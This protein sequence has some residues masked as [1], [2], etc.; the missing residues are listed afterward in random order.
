LADYEQL[1]LKTPGTQID[2]VAVRANFDP[3]LRAKSFSGTHTLVILPVLGTP[4]SAGLRQAVKNYLYP[5]RVIGT[6]V[7][8]IG[9]TF[10]EVAVRA[11]V[12]AHS[13]I[14]KTDLKQKI[15]EALNAFFDP[16]TGGPDHTG[17]PLGRDVYRSEV[18]QAIDE[19]PGVDH[20]L[21]LALTSNGGQ[22]QSG[23]LQMP[24]TSL[25]KAEAGEHQIEVV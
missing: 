21:T 11:S 8:V 15:E 9:P 1:A 3:K 5:R 14:N 13:G 22:P 25:V 24:P 12:K 2:R 7:E 4:P 10:I 17:W 20:V 6:D 16:L 23:N 19:V 18:L